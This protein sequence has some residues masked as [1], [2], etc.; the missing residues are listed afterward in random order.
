MGR[1]VFD[2]LPVDTFFRYRVLEASEI[3]FGVVV[4]GRVGRVE[5]PVP[6]C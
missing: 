2:L 3:F 1:V 4:Y 6:I 5:K